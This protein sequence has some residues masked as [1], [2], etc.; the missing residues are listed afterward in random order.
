MKEYFK[1]TNIITKLTGLDLVQ[2]AIAI[3]P[4]EF[5]DDF[6]FDEEWIKRNLQ[7]G[8]F[9][10]SINRSWK[11]DWSYYRIYQKELDLYNLDLYNED[12]PPDTE[13]DTDT[14][15]FLLRGLYRIVSPNNKSDDN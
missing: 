15:L 2:K 9:Y 3:V 7:R 13:V 5:V 1:T 6:L 14:F 8:I 4:K 10:L 12:G 11:L